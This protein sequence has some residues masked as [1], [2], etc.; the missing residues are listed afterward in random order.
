MVKNGQIWSKYDELTSYT[1]SILPSNGHWFSWRMSNALLFLYSIIS[2]LESYVKW[3]KMSQIG[4]KW[5]KSP[6]IMWESTRNTEH[7]VKFY[8]NHN[9]HPFSM[10]LIEFYT[11]LI[12]IWEF[13]W[14]YPTLRHS[15]S[16]NVL[17]HITFQTS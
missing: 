13:V 7:E 15:V 5:S 9:E 1:L 8:K 10:A 6:K 3:S 4:L 12:G 14:T 17:F 16:N 11:Y 2:S